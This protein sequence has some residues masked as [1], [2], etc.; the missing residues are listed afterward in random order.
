MESPSLM[1]FRTPGQHSILLIKRWT[2]G[3]TPWEPWND[4][5]NQIHSSEG[6]R[7]TFSTCASHLMAVSIFFGTTV[8]MYLRPSSSYFS[9]QDKWASMFYT[10]VIPMMNPLI[11]SLR[12]KEVKEALR[13]FQ[14]WKILG[15]FQGC[16]K[17]VSLESMLSN[18]LKSRSSPASVSLQQKIC[19]KDMSMANRTTVTK[20]ILLGFPSKPV[21]QVILFLVFSTMYSM[22]LLG[23]IGLMVL[24]RSN[25]HLQTPMYFF[26]SNLSF[27][28]LCYCSVIVPKMLVNFL[29]ERKTI[30]YAGCGLQFYFFCTFA[31]TESFILATMAYDRYVAICNP[32]LYTVT[33]SQKVC[34][35]LVLL[36]YLG[37]TLSALV[38]TC[39][40]FRLSFCGPN[41]INHFFCDLPL[42]LKLSCSDTTLNELL[43][44]TYGSS[45]EIISSIIIIISYIFIIISVLK[46]R[47]M[48][49][50][51]KTFSTCA[52]HL[53]SVIIYEGTLLFI[54]SRPSSWYSP[55]SDKYISVFYTIVVPVLNPL[56]Y[57]L[58]NKD[59]KDALRKA[60]E[61]KAIAQ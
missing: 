8:F 43:L 5:A 31:D 19:Y 35:M 10:V 4:C 24:I 40:A 12:N 21:I 33:M 51:R 16:Q 23:N 46:M 7:K 26:L 9:D 32:L 27:V 48:A 34:V 6:K 47:C 50:R 22:V 57:S 29:S 38:H 1:V 52:S 18:I 61:S 55:N 59:V 15:N 45:V 36:S 11:Y 17:R 13:K 53:T 30:S 37:G 44:Y 54:Y 49:A 42:L 56:I 28:D 14:Q 58:R 2:R 20:F 60:I 25:S 41:I 3:M 39:F